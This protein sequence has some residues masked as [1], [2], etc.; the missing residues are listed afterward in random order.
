MMESNSM[1]TP[2]LAT[3]LPVREVMM[4]PASAAVPP[5]SVKAMSLIRRIGRPD[6]LPAVSFRPIT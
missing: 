1:P 6:S 3:V 2:A 5:Q 4:R